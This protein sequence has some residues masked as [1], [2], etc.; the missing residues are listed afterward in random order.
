MRSVLFVALLAGFSSASWFS[1]R[2]TETATPSVETEVSETVNAEPITVVSEPVTAVS[3]PVTEVK[4]EVTEVKTEVTEAKTEVTP[5]P[6]AS[7]SSWWWPLS[8][9]NA[10]PSQLSE[11]DFE[12]IQKSTVEQPQPAAPIDESSDE[13]PDLEALFSNLDSY[14]VQE[15]QETPQT[16]EKTELIQDTVQ[17]ETSTEVQVTEQPLGPRRR[18]P[19]LKQI[20]LTKTATMS[21]IAKY[22][23][24][25]CKDPSYAR[26]SFTA[27]NPT[28]K[29]R[30]ADLARVYGF[31]I[32]SESTRTLSVKRAKMNKMPERSAVQ[33]FVVADAN[34][35]AAA[36]SS[37]A[38]KGS[39][40][41]APVIETETKP[42]NKKGR[43]EYSSDEEKPNRRGRVQKGRRGASR[44]RQRER[45]Q[46]TAAQESAR[47]QLDEPTWLGLEERI[48]AVDL[49]DTKTEAVRG[50]STELFEFFRDLGDE[51]ERPEDVYHWQMGDETFN[52][53]DGNRRHDSEQSSSSSSSSTQPTYN[54]ADFQGHW[55][56]EADTSDWQPNPL[57]SGR[58]YF[59]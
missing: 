59:M 23:D 33:Q 32:L 14:V 39:R 18:Q 51:I 42:L 35:R 20:R 26:Y 36:L 54:A 46:K 2:R 24:E 44:L 41:K 22:F 1:F 57:L 43:F 28:L 38:Y 58:R 10:Q 52:N 6:Q 5:A 31:A 7:A 53:S 50:E 37:R 34:E 12:L 13:M 17:E 30:I 40:V 27:I 55:L 3:E 15:T 25:L 8:Y 29:K 19:A 11:T 47:Q 45:R 49:Q 48:A 9:W 56:F 21:D 4:T 16:F